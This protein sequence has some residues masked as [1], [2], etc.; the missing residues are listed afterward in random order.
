M[1]EKIF[2]FTTFILVISA[3][4]ANTVI[5]HKSIGQIY[6]AVSD[7]EIYEG[8]CKTAKIEAESAF[9][10]F[11]K[12]ELFIGLTVNHDDL[13]NIES[14]FSELI[15]YLSVDDAK[16]ATVA[17]SRL[18]DSLGHLRRLSGFNIDAII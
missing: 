6:D 8:A 10:I 14:N 11:R 13:S 3:V 15:G 5:L 7:V 1:K 17:K 16:G 9:H 2:G 4:F 12:K 18:A